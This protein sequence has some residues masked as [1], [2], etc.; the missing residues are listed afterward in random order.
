MMYIDCGSTDANFNFALETYLIKQLCVS[1]EYFMF[2]RTSPTLMT[3]R[4]QNTLA[5]I[6]ME[7]AKQHD[8]SIVRRITGGGT[9]YTDMNGW[10]FS[11]I[12]KRK[13]RLEF[14]TFTRPI[15]EALASLGIQAELTGRNDLTIGGRKFSGNAQYIG[16]D[17]MLHHGSILF[18]TDLEALVRA[19]SVDDEKIISKGIKSVRQ[20]VTN[21]AEH[22]L[23]QMT[24]L[25]FRDV[26][27][28]YL[29]RDM[30]TYELTPADIDSV[31]EIKRSQFDTWEWNF[32][33][34]PKFNVTKEQRFAGGKLSSKVLVEHGLIAGIKFYGDFFASE[35]LG[36]LEA[37]LVGCRYS[38]ADIKSAL[39]K[40]HVEECFY[41]ITANEVLSCII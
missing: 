5:E 19:L 6:N 20:R 8:I 29:L 16:K 10:Q 25:E 37:S 34:D 22:L 21:V 23:K 26:M 12:V 32:G 18:D 15:I 31:N 2:W 41:N 13:G 7:Y 38:E 40:S 28:S 14:E 24:S 1:D 27:L 4:F 11:F 9:I 33:S 39:E 17:V 36:Q 35:A 30:D 3:G